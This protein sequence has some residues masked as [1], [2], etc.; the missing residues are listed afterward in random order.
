MRKKEM[1]FMGVYPLGLG[2]GA[3]LISIL[4]E[5][6]FDSSIWINT[7]CLGIIGVWYGLGYR[8]GKE[9]DVSVKTVFYIHL[10]PLFVFL[11]QVFVM[12][13]DAYKTEPLLYIFGEVAFFP[14]Y[15]L[16]SFFLNLNQAV[17]ILISFVMMVCVFSLGMIMGQSER[18]S[19]L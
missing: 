4:F 15:Q 7:V 11:L 6:L 10:V 8:T 3:L 2:G 19:I 13:L 18:R 9:K 16:V 1:L 14:A 12:R 17:S 5:R